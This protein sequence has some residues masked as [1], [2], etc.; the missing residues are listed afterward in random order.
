MITADQANALAPPRLTAADVKFMQGMI[1]HHA[2]AMEMTSLHWT[3]STTGHEE[4]RAADRASQ[5]DEIRMMK[6]W[7]QA[8]GRRCRTSMRT[9]GWR[10]ADAGDADAGRDG[11]A[12]GRTGPEFDQLFL[13]EHDPAPLGA[14][15]MV[16][17]LGSR[18]PGGGQ[19]SEIFAFASDV[20]ADQRMEIDR[21]GAMLKERQK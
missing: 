8:R 10:Q 1:G 19:E 3:R 9:T 15:T 16:K 6:E 12:G 4:D 7:L 14:L 2:Q 5:A 20:D 21:M 18:P 11:P 17:G 13:E